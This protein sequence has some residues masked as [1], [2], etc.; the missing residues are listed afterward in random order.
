[1]KKINYTNVWVLSLRTFL[2]PFYYGYGSY[3]SGS[4]S[5]QILER[6]RERD[7]RTDMGKKDREGLACCYAHSHSICGKH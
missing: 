7:T 2:I 4:V 1:M 5:P 3:G 6:G